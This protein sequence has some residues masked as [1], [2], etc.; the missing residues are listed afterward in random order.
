M[1]KVLI[2]G[3][4]G[5]IGSHLALALLKKGY[6]I[7]VLDNLS[8]QVHGKKP[9]ADSTLYHSIK[10]K[11]TFIKGDVTEVSSWEKAIS[12]NEIIVHL[13][14]ET[15]TG[16]SMYQAERY[17]K[18]NIGGTAILLDYLV[19][20]KH[21]VKKVL[22]ASSRA[23]YGEGKYFSCNWALYTQIQGCRMR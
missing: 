22:V 1:K 13:A 18:A 2:S 17:T 12:G 15:G 7:T 23:I 11:V 9:E 21:Q 6:E 5:F 8:E 10:E 4:A 20:N 19:N 16:Q 14:A 3:G